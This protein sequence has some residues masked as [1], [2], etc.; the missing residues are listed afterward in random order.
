MT[1][2]VHEKTL[3]PTNTVATS[4]S[5]EASIDKDD[6]GQE[7]TKY[8]SK[9]T[10][11]GNGGAYSFDVEE[12]TA[13]DSPPQDA[14]TVS[15]SS[16]IAS[17]FFSTTFKRKKPSPNTKDREEDPMYRDFKYDIASNFFF[18][19]GTV[20][21]LVCSVWN[22][23]YNAFAATIDPAK[24]EADDD[25]TWSVIKSETAF[26][27]DY[28]FSLPL[29]NRS[30]DQPAEYW[31]SLLQMMLFFG[32]LSILISGIIDF[33]HYFPGSEEEKTVWSWCCHDKV[34]RAFS[35]LKPLQW[36]AV[37]LILGGLFGML[38]AILMQNVVA[39]TSCNFVSIHFYLLEASIVLGSEKRINEENLS[40]AKLLCAKYLLWSGQGLFF[41]GTFIDVTL[42][43]F[44]LFP[45]F[46][47]SI[48]IAIGEMFAVSLWVLCALLYMTSTI[49]IYRIHRKK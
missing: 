37:F 48:A 25:Y 31:V 34:M 45:Q 2:E 17:R 33:I 14:T 42:S 4:D 20:L 38:S 40:K 5:V 44:Y 7:A 39:S 32:A 10:A 21:Y 41:V 9:K 16:H 24:L 13:S 23:Q 3:S 6:I 19:F 35:F 28:V 27:D 46:A 47:Y 8:E 29:Y 1:M 22:Y 43:Y 18:L 49:F 11:D 36:A 26:E 12:G 30:A 15:K